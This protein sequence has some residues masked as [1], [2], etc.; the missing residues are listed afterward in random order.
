MIFSGI[1][2]LTAINRLCESKQG[3]VSE[4]HVGRKYYCDNGKKIA[5]TV[6]SELQ[7]IHMCLSQDSC[8]MVN[9][10]EESYVCEV[11]IK[12]DIVS[13]W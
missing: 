13:Y 10:L 2:I 11:F 9:H 1:F 8:R 7:C 4:I 5:K 3:I 6:K 12:N